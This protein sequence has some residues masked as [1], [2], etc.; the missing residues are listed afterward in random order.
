MQ[1]VFRQEHKFLISLMESKKQSGYISHFLAQDPHNGDHPAGYRIRSLYFDT[2]NNQDFF[3]KEEGIETR[4]KIRLR[5]YDPAGDFAMLEMK[6]KQG[7]E[8]LKRSLKLTRAHAIQLT[9][10]SYSVLLSYNDPFAAECFAI[11]NMQ[12]Y[13]PKAVVEY[14]RR[15]FIAKENKTRV[16][17]DSE[18]TGTE[19]S[20]DVFSATLP[21]YPILSGDRVV[22]EVKYNGFLLSYIQN[23]IRDCNKSSESVSKYCLGRSVGLKYLF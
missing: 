7:A 12:C 18:L 9:K 10:G 1:Q 23:M 17:F 2:L 11:M 5:L 19:S 22:L 20:F 16:T 3:D 15:A 21:L 6:Q 14:R 4:R 8:Q 13:R